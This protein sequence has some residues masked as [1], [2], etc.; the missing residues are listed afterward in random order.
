MYLFLLTKNTVGK[1]ST[2]WHNILWWLFSLFKKIGLLWQT[3]KV[4]HLIFSE[5]VPNTR[6]YKKRDRLPS[7]SSQNVDVVRLWHQNLMPAHPY[8]KCRAIKPLKPHIYDC[9]ITAFHFYTKVPNTRI[10]NFLCFKSFPKSCR[11]GYMRHLQ[12]W[13]Y[14]LLLSVLRHLV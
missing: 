3:C 4:K 2:V 13:R 8:G 7:A 9:K 11:A 10:F 14:L 1:K 6:I 5:K 12:S